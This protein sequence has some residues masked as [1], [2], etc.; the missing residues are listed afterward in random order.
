[1]SHIEG[2][3]KLN[4]YKSLNNMRTITQE[5]LAPS[6]KTIIF[7]TNNNKN[8]DNIHTESHLSTQTNPIKQLG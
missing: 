1:M 8:L 7:K 6:Q 3:K 4:H 2:S 5:S